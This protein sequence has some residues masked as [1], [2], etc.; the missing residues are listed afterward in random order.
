[1]LAY[2][3]PRVGQAYRCTE[4][5]YKVCDILHM[6]HVLVWD[7]NKF[8]NSYLT[9]VHHVVFLWRKKLKSRKLICRTINIRVL[10]L[11]IFI[12][13]HMILSACTIFLLDFFCVYHDIKYHVYV[14]HPTSVFEI[15]VLN[16]RQYFVLLCTLTFVYQTV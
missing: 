8:G 11:E 16:Q 14:M 9:H 10:M 15:T 4:E 2:L 6:C 3:K 1:M 13:L 7:K 5:K 12:M